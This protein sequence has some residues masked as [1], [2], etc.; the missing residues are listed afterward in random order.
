[1]TRF[2]FVRHG[3]SI[4]NLEKIFAGNYDVDLS[5]LGHKQAQFTADFVSKNY[6][7][8]AIYS[9]D[10]KRAYETAE[11]IANL[12]G[13]EIQKE[14]GMR[15]INAGKWE[16]C[17]FEELAIKYVDDYEIWL[18]DIGN[19]RCTEGE[20]VAELAKRVYVTIKQIADKNPNRTVLIT[21]HGTPIRA[22]QLHS[23]GSPL[24]NM[25][26]IPWVSNASVTEM[27]YDNGKLIPINIA[28]D[29]HLGELRS[30]LP[31][32]V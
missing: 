18:T 29:A 30:V 11:Y 16:G 21:T 26:E 5:S 12:L 23:T 15:E 6:Q 8:D 25:K 32:N 24:S 31:A 20:S 19:A 10:L 1:M 27:V 22:L 3:Q 9:S 28:L 2:I 14:P 17:S 13:L 7:V 4:A